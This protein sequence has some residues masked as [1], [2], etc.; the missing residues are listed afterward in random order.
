MPKIVKQARRKIAH[1]IDHATEPARAG[2]VEDA[3]LCS[4]QVHHLTAYIARTVE[5]APP[6][7]AEQRSRLGALLRADRNA[8]RDGGSER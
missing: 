2:G 6:L 1:A 4:R 8:S 3:S 7:T 5:A